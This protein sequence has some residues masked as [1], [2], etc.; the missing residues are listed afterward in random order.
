MKIHFLGVHNCESSD[1][2]LLSLLIDDS[3]VLDAGGL[4]SNLSFAAQLRL[5][6]VLL[7]HQHYDH[8]R[9]IPM[10]AMHLYLSGAAI[11][12][13]AV[14]SVGDAL[15]KNL[16]N[17]E[18]YSK[19]FEKPPDNPTIRFHAIEPCRA[20]DIIGYRVLP[21]PVSH[22]SSSVGYQITSAEGRSFFYS[23]DTGP[24]LAH[25]WRR[26]SPELLIMDVIAPN[27]FEQF[28]R[29]SKH[30]TPSLLKEELLS[31]RKINGYLPPVVA[32]HMNPNLEGEI[33]VEI[34]AV[35]RELDCSLTLAHEGM[36]I[37]L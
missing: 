23:G 22:A 29:D 1:T 19:F 35:A 4:T 34:A 33:E 36:E 7:S 20:E 13:Y 17:G 6:A 27:R 5:K 28:G 8:I 18:L 26:I 30:L 37:S 3:L 21:V 14:P 16:L 15:Q 10:L 11:D 12:I 24:G 2:R 25:C 32:V 9:D 31:F